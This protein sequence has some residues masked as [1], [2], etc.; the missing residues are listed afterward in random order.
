MRLVKP[1]D[2]RLLTP[3]HKILLR[4]DDLPR[5]QMHVPGKTDRA[6]GFFDTL[7]RKPIPPERQNHRKP[8]ERF[9]FCVKSV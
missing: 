5:V 6:V 8:L 9:A 2:V 3:T 1:I 4:L 7:R